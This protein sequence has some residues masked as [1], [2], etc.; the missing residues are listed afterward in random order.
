MGETTYYG[1]D[2]PG[3]PTGKVV[4]NEMKYESSPTSWASQPC[5]L[6]VDNDIDIRWTWETYGCPSRGIWTYNPNP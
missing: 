2:V 6:V 1:S 5:G 4:F 3:R